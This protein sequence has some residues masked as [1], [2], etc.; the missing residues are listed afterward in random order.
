M[1][2]TTYQDTF[3]TLR[4]DYTK[5]NALFAKENLQAIAARFSSFADYLTVKKLWNIPHRKA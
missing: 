1:P 3:N 2:I 5:F 4:G